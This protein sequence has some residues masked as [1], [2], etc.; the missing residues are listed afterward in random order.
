VGTAVPK[1]GVVGDCKS[2]IGVTGL[3]DGIGVYGLSGANS[4]LSSASAG[5]LERGL[6]GAVL[7][8]SAAPVNLR[9]A[10]SSSHPS[11][12]AA[13]DLFVDSAKWLW[14]CQGDSTWKQIV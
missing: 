9:P 2:G 3:S 4:G 12:G 5:L 10:S 7:S 1:S 11:S 14:F 13:G 6:R 8:G